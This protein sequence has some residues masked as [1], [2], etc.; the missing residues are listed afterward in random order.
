MK[1]LRIKNAAI[2]CTLTLLSL[3]STG[4]HR[5]SVW[6]VDAS[7]PY[8]Q[9]PHRA[10]SVVFDSPTVRG[11]HDPW[12][13]TPRPTPWYASRNDFALSTVSGYEGATLDQTVNITIDRQTTN[14]GRS[15]DHFSSTTI[16]RQVT[17]NLR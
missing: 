15:R 1:T 3:A 13:A 10:R 14:S 9:V 17:E 6:R 8:P 4:C 7:L 16:R 11:S 2:V 12:I 5:P